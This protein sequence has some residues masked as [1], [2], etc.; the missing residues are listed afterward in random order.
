MKKILIMAIIFVLIGSCNVYAELGWDNHFQT[1][2]E[3]IKED[4]DMQDHWDRLS[5][6]YKYALTKDPQYYSFSNPSWCGKDYPSVTATGNTLTSVS[7]NYVRYLHSS[8]QDVKLHGDDTVYQ[9]I[10]PNQ[11][12]LTGK[13]SSSDKTVLRDS[14]QDFSNVD[15][16]WKVYVVG[17][18][19]DGTRLNII[20]VINSN[21]LKLSSYQLDKTGNYR[22]E[23]PFTFSLS[24][25]VSDGDYVIHPSNDT[26]YRPA[27]CKDPS[28]NEVRARLTGMGIGYA[29]V[30]DI[31]T[32]E[33]RRIRKAVLDNFLDHVLSGVS[34]SDSDEIISAYFGVQLAYQ[35]IK[36]D[37]PIRAEQIINNSRVSDWKER[38]DLM[39]SEI[40]DQD[41]AQWIEG[42][43]YS[44]NTVSMLIRSV[45]YLRL[46][47]GDPIFQELIDKLPLIATGVKLEF[48]R[49][50]D[51][52]I[53]WNDSQW[54]YDVVSFRRMNMFATIADALHIEHGINDGELWWLIDKMN[55]VGSHDFTSSATAY[56]AFW[57]P[58]AER[59]EPNLRGTFNNSDLGLTYHHNDTSSVM[60]TTLIT[61]GFDHSPN[62]DDI[63]LWRNGELLI[64]WE[65]GYSS[66]DWETHTNNLAPFGEQL[67]FN[68][69]GQSEFMKGSGWFYV[70]GN[71]TNSFI[72]EQ[73]RSVFYSQ[74]NGEDLIIIRDVIDHTLESNADGNPTGFPTYKHEEQV[75]MQAG[76]YRHQINFYIP[77][78]NV[79]YGTNSWSWLGNAGKKNYVEGVERVTLKTYIADYQSGIYNNQENVGSAYPYIDMGSN[80]Q[81]RGYS[82]RI[83]PLDKFG[84]QIYY[85]T[86]NTGNLNIIRDGDRFYI[87]GVE[88]SFDPFAVNLDGDPIPDPCPECP[89]CEECPECP[90]PVVCPDPIDCSEI[91]E[92]YQKLIDALG[93]IGEHF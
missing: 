11:T 88:V 26:Y 15:T 35:A 56:S 41:F 66:T 4:P 24:S 1:R 76:D 20:E 5:T 57:N 85:H 54:I 63:F 12:I 81:L 49:P 40:G 79:E 60:V 29:L 25:N 58:Y 90:E 75:Q 52:T 65:R 64:D 84:R 70:K 83:E 21:S 87:D 82:L 42:T 34:L 6:S 47:T 73:S 32:D 19:Y 36:D 31:T 91:E 68:N 55:E 16:S 92:K 37:Y 3:Q 67:A 86:I 14:S 7:S 17:G 43:Y 23:S 38:I 59:T 61:T 10:N 13:N 9:I 93:L 28:N 89:V 51:T 69:R 48:L 45:I 80:H 33:Q 8:G 62:A 77:T 27:G 39:I 53:Q 22:I 72:T 78:E 18:R 50:Y 74:V 2:W 30:N 71:R 44:P 46:H